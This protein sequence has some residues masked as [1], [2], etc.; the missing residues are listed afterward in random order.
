MSFGFSTGEIVGLTQLALQITQNCRKACGE[1]AEL[2]REVANLHLVIA[3]LQKEADTPGSL[4]NRADDLTKDELRC[5]ITDCGMVLRILDKILMKYNGMSEEKRAMRKLWTKIRF[6]NGEMQ[7]LRDLR[8]KIEIYASAITLQLNLISLGSQGRVEKQLNN[9]G[10]ELRAMRQSLNW[11]TASLSTGHE[12]SILTTYSGDDKA[13][14]KELRRELVVEGY[15][16]SIIFRHKSLIIAYVKELGSRGALDDNRSISTSHLAVASNHQFP[17][18][19][20]ERDNHDSLSELKEEPKRSRTNRASKG[21]YRKKRT[22]RRH[23]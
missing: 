15:S 16:S 23:R 12:G 13:V 9:Q 7:D 14:W 17:V 19:R 11:I 5:T 10:S 20:T 6:G 3:R 1:H 8:E 2:T 4:L 18:Q 21:V 22:R